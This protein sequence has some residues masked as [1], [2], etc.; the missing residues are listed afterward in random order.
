MDHLNAGYLQLGL[1]ALAFGGLQI[2]WI[3]SRILAQV[4][5]YSNSLGVAIA[6]RTY[7]TDAGSE[8]GALRELLDR[9]DLTG[10]L[11]QADALHANRP[12]SSTA[13]RGA[14]FLFAVKHCRR[15]GFQVICD[16]LTYGRK[17]P[18]EWS[19]RE[20]R[21]GRDLRWRLRGMPAPQ[22]VAENWPCSATILAVRCKGVREGE[23]IDVD[24]VGRRP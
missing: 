5:L 9:A 14:D 13:R 23:P 7:A 17:A 6:Q 24:T 21:R 12:F 8:F 2:W 19:H 4:S 16:R 15:R 20:R 3:S 22:W 1:F 10:M 11:V 18:Y